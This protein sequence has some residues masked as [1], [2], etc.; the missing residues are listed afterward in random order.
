MGIPRLEFGAGDVLFLYALASPAILP[1]ILA[2]WACRKGRRP[3]VSAML[4]YPLV[5]I[6]APA[7]AWF[8]YAVTGFTLHNQPIGFVAAGCAALAEGFIAGQLSSGPD[9]DGIS[10]RTKS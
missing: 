10:G 5:A 8:G 4:V 6:A 3:L 7:V 2:C 9:L 1:A